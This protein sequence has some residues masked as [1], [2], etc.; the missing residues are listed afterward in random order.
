MHQYLVEVEKT[1]CIMMEDR[2]ES[3]VHSAYVVKALCLCH[4]VIVNLHYNTVIMQSFNFILPI[5]TDNLHADIA[6][7]QSTTSS[8]LLILPTLMLLG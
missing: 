6:I 4:G 5:V 1:W 2:G 3:I 7:L 8:D